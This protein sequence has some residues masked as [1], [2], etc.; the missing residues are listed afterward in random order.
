M[1]MRIAIA[2]EEPSGDSAGL[3]QGFDE[4]ADLLRDQPIA[5]CLAA[6]HLDVP[7]HH[8]CAS[9]A[10]QSRRTMTASASSCSRRGS[11]ILRTISSVAAPDPTPAAGS[12]PE[13]AA[14]DRP[15][16]AR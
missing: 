6:V 3:L 5:D 15:R 12:R 14:P 2:D 16:R 10:P 8:A 13:P 7:P 4:R 11:E 9:V 1:V